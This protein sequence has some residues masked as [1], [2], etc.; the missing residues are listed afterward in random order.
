MLEI[1][2]YRE[3][4]TFYDPAPFPPGPDRAPCAAMNIIWKTFPVGPLQ[5]NCTVL[6]DP[7]TGKG[8]V[9]DAGGDAQRI[10]DVASTSGLEIT[11]IVQTH[12]HLDH[13]LAAGQVH[14]ATG[15]P[16]WLH[17]ADRFLWDGAEQQCRMWGLP[18]SPLPD[19][20]CELEHGQELEFGCRCIH[21]PGHTPGSVSFYFR[22][23][24]LLIAGDTLFQG[25]VGRT[26]LPGGS[27]AQLKASIQERLYVLD[28]STVVITGHGPETRIGQEKR[29]NAFVR[30]S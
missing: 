7:G 17:P 16:V 2:F 3:F 4:F 24:K 18:Y 11:G 5:S 28:D 13:I 9:F 21:T 6:G 23:E 20:T 19:P 1:A 8:Y 26:D 25:S 10:L 12:A 15:S 14:D 27:S 30:A 22:N 29:F